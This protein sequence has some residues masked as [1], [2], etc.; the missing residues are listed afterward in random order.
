MYSD[1]KLLLAKSGEIR[2]LKSKQLVGQ[3][4]RKIDQYIIKKTKK[5]LEHAHKKGDTT[6][7]EINELNELV[8]SL[9]QDLE[10]KAEACRV[11]LRDKKIHELSPFV[12]SPLLLCSHTCSAIPAYNQPTGRSGHNRGS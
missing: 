7:F 12:L 11:H 6:S 10:D 9:R 8:L 1:K 3:W 5:A 2:R 4:K